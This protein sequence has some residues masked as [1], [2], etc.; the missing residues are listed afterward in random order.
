MGCDIAPEPASHLSHGLQRQQ[1]RARLQRAS[2][3]QH[4]QVG[5]AGSVEAGESPAGCGREQCRQH[6]PS[7]SATACRTPR[8]AAGSHL[9]VEW[10]PLRIA[11]RSDRQLRQAGHH[12]TAKRIQPCSCCAAGGALRRALGTSAQ[13]QRRLQGGGTIGSTICL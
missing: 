1:A 10:L 3:H 11:A 7:H 13:L 12:G 2:H 4:L 5:R 6:L 8:N 9:V